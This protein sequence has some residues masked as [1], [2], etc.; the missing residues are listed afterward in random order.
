MERV[1]KERSGLSSSPPPSRLFVTERPAKARAGTRHTTRRD[2][3]QTGR[4]RLITAHREG[5]L[6]RGSRL[7]RRARKV[8]GE[9]GGR[10]A[11]KALCKQV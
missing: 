11:E 7:I 9:Q 1:G 6:R 10:E 4:A 3:P 2:D 5:L 8:G